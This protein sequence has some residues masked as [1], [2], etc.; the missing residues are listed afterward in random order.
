MKLFVGIIVLLLPIVASAETMKHGEPLQKALAQQKF[1][2]KKIGLFT[3]MSRPEVVTDG[4]GLL[5]ER[6]FGNRGEQ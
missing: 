1:P 4:F 3:K 6:D 5:V 2:P